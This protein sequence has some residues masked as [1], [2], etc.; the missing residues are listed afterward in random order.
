MSNVNDNAHEHYQSM[1]VWPA[2]DLLGRDVI[3]KYDHIN[4]A[5][6]GCSFRLYAGLLQMIQIEL[7]LTYIK[8]STQ[9]KCE[10]IPEIIQFQ[11]LNFH[12]SKSTLSL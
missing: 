2:R 12:D 7:S 4:Y 5:F 8:L 3:I 11:L 1:Q 10:A 9:K 6:C